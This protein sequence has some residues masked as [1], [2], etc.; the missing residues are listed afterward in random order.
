V[1]ATAAAA[2]EGGSRGS[3]G[4]VAGKA[5]IGVSNGC[6]T[7]AC[8]YQLMRPPPAFRLRAFL[9]LISFGRTDVYRF[10]GLGANARDEILTL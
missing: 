9:A 7:G 2:V 8:R 1:A 6:G 10:Y 3:R 5:I 4:Q